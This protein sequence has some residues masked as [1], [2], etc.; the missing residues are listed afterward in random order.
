MR[1]GA[2][3]NTID[4]AAASA[5]AVAVSNCPGKNA[6]AVAELAWGL[7]LALDRRLVE[8]AVDLRNGVWNKAEYG[9]ARG[10]AGRTLGVVGLGAIGLEVV[11]RGRRPS[12]C[13]SSPGADRWTTTSRPASASRAPTRSTRSRPR[14]T[15]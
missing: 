9:K 10:L 4:L 1:A 7:I 8:Q 2:G 15:S 12:G 11:A 5:R 3:V 14:P 13:R 6:I